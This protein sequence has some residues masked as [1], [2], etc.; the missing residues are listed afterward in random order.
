M[1]RNQ[2]TE[3]QTEP[4]KVCYPILLFL[5]LFNLPPV[6]IEDLRRLFIKGILE[7]VCHFAEEKEKT[8]LNIIKIRF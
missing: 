5:T 6:L 4:G 8:V 7:L 2:G 3:K 1:E